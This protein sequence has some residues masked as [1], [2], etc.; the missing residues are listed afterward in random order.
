MTIFKQLRNNARTWWHHSDL[1]KRGAHKEAR[2]LEH[3]SIRQTIKHLRDAKA[4]GGYLS[5]AGAQWSLTIYE[6]APNW[7]SSKQ[8]YS[9]QGYYSAD[10]SCY[11]ENACKLLDIPTLDSRAIDENERVSFALKMP[12]I[13]RTKDFKDESPMHS[14]SYV[15]IETYVKLAAKYK[16]FKSMGVSL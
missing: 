14:L 16:G 3:K 2:S 5:L 10:D 9:V 15:S 4:Y 6:H 13:A 7:T 8:T 1:R 12:L 11:L